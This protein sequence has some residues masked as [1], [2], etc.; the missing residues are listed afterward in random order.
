MKFAL[1]IIED[2]DRACLGAGQLSR[3]GDDG[4]EDVLQVEGRVHRMRHFAERAQFLDRAAKLIG[5][6]AQRIQ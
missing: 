5:A 6:I 2:V 3:L 4:R 1:H